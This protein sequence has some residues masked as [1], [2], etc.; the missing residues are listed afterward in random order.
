MGRGP[1]VSR[2]RRVRAYVGLGT[3]LGDRE[4]VLAAAVTALD[5]LPGVRVVGVSR[6]Y[7]TRPVGVVDQPDFRNACVA[8][9]VA[10][11]EAPAV[12]AVRLLTRLKELERAAGRRRGR[13][14]G[15]RPLDLDL[16]VF[17]RHRIRVE[18]PPRARTSD[19]T[20]DPEAARWLV[21]P[22]PEAQR[23]RFVLAPLAD[24]A[25]SLRPPGW[26]E[27]VATAA[28]RQLGVEGPDAVRPLGRW[29]AESAR[30]R[31]LPAG[32]AG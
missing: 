29:D 5:A 17:G 2:P 6:L 4:A 23:R 1:V 26:A 7:A 10:V 12:V 13:R 8:L 14:W 19:P 22:H 27:T 32:P 15:P 28:R 25:P 31:P 18:R 20:A 30:W 16:L 24:L 11:S 3:N 9:D 21:V